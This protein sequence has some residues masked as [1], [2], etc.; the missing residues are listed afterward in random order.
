MEDNG[1]EVC[2]ST[3]NI[4][5]SKPPTGTEEDS[6]VYSEV[7]Q[8]KAAPAQTSQEKKETAA[9]CRSRLMLVC[10]GILC[11]LLVV[12]ITVIVYMSR[13]TTMQ[14]TEINNLIKENERV[15]E[16]NKMMQNKNK[17]LSRERDDLNKTLGIIQTFDDFPVKDYCSDKGCKPCQNNW[18][19]FQK[20]C[21]FFF[22]GPAHWKTW[23]ES[24]KFCQDNHA[25][26]VVIDDLE[27]QEFVSNHTKHYYDDFHGYWMGLH[28]TNNNWT[29]VDGRRDTL[30][31]WMKKVFGTPGPAA[32]LIPG[33]NLTENWD[34]AE[35]K[36]NNKFICSGRRRRTV[37]QNQEHC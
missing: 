25:D 8:K 1:N 24:R 17:E 26:L 27:E 19:L 2:Y 20:K 33:G 21:Y 13:K 22:E 10:L 12:S 37:N 9:L 28:Q 14:Q 16:E 35:D 18:I 23:T 3:V 11:V 4:K 15:T 32:L 30:G 36:F 31:F 6:T 34:K 5:N 29:W 7:K